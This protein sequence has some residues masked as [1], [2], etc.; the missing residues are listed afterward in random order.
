MAVLHS[1]SGDTAHKNLARG[2]FDIF[3]SDYGSPELME[4]AV[5]GLARVSEQLKDWPR[6]RQCWME[7]L[8]RPDWKSAREE[9]LQGIDRVQGLSNEQDVRPVVNRS[10]VSPKRM[11]A[12]ERVENPVMGIGGKLASRIE[13]AEKLLRSGFSEKALEIL[14]KVVM[15]GGRIR[16]PDADVTALIHRAGIL[17]ENLQFELQEY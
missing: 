4:R 8:S 10:A 3:L 6:A 17:R 15:D 1:A 9:A 13:R 14:G 12:R 7:Y 11:V 2:G 5:L 16:K